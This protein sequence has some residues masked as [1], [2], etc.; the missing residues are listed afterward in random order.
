MLTAPMSIYV[1]IGQGT[2]HQL[3]NLLMLFKV[4]TKNIDRFTLKSVNMVSS[5]HH[6]VWRFDCYKVIVMEAEPYK[7]IVVVFQDQS[8]MEIQLGVTSAG[9]VVFQNNVRINTFSWWEFHTSI[10]FFS[11]IKFSFTSTDGL[12][13]HFLMKIWPIRTK[14]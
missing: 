4:Q 5:L 13:T 3:I 8:N 9:L 2:S 1:W 10:F 11:I 6:I 14:L 7:E 12:V